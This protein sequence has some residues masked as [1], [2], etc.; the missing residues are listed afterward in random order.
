M[1]IRIPISRLRSSEQLE[2]ADSI[3][4]RVRGAAGSTQYPAPFQAAFER[5]TDSSDSLRM[6][7]KRDNNSRNTA[8]L[9]A[10]DGERDIWFGALSRLWNVYA[11][12]PEGSKKEAGLALQHHVGLYGGANKVVN[13]SYLGQTA[14]LKRILADYTGKPEL[15]AALAQTDGTTLVAALEDANNRFAAKWK[16]RNDQMVEDEMPDSI[17]GLRKRLKDDYDKL[18]DLVDAFLLSTAGAAPWDGLVPQL[19]ALAVEVNGMLA[20]RSGRAEAKK[21]EAP[22]A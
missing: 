16:Q 18:M 6:Q 4:E 21:K 1:T 5:F 20:V 11:C 19:N 15:A 22:S 9:E 10:I 12:F 3:I 8:E 13:Q 7:H 17:K 14:D 2:T